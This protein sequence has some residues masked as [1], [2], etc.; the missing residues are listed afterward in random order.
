MGAFLAGNA[1]LLAVPPATRRE[2]LGDVPR[3]AAKRAWAFYDHSVMPLVPR[4]ARTYMPTP[5][6]QWLREGKLGAALES[7]IL[8]ALHEAA[9]DFNCVGGMI[10]PVFCFA[11]VPLLALLFLVGCVLPAQRVNDAKFTVR[12]LRLL[13]LFIVSLVVI[14]VLGGVLWRSY[15]SS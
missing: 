2:L 11:Y 6:V 8:L 7:D 14:A 12:D 10:F 15:S 5:L 4:E 3:A 9:R 1:F 13:A